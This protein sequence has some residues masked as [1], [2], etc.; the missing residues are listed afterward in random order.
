[1]YF[2]FSHFCE[3]FKITKQQTYKTYIQQFNYKMIPDGI[4]IE[5]SQESTNSKYIKQFVC[6][7][8]NMAT[9]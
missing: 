1:M 3:E 7:Y 6:L 4:G 9:V 8:T 2:L 5:M